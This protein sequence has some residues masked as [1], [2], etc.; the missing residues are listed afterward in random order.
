[1]VAITSIDIKGHRDD[2][3]P[4][5]LYRQEGGDDES[6]SRPRRLAIVLPGLGYTV[7]M[8]VLWYPRRLCLALGMDVLTVEYAY[9]ERPEFSP[10]GAEQDE[11]LLADVRA[12]YGAA[13]QGQPY[14]DVVLIGKSLGTLGMG[15]LIESEDLLQHDRAIWLTPLI[16]RDLLRKQIRRWKGRSLFIIGTDDPHYRADWVAEICSSDR[17]EVLVLDRADHA[18]EVPGDV[19]RSVE[20]MQRQV[21]TIAAFLG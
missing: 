6:P 11:W 5:T 3:V 18:L 2:P 7:H 15:A 8:P 13:L 10:W 20:Y 4:N 9:M 19:A 1:M 16:G 12:A 17:G 21:R 14:D